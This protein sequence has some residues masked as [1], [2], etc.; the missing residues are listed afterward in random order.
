MVI[1]QFH[2]NLN[3]KKSVTLSTA[4]VEFVSLTECAKQ[5]IWFKNLIKEIFNKENKN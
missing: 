1:V 2:R 3:N 4:E 5:G